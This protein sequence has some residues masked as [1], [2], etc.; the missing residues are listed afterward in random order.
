MCRIVAIMVV[1][2][3]VACGESGPLLQRDPTADNAD[4]VRPPVDE[5]TDE[6]DSDDAVEPTVETDTSGPATPSDAG[7]VDP[8]ADVVVEP[9]EPDSANPDTAGVEDTAP[10]DT[11]VDAPTADSNDGDTSDASDVP[12]KP[13]SRD[14]DTPPDVSDPPDTSYDLPEFVRIEPGTFIMGSPVT[15]PG[16]PFRSDETQHSVTLTRA[17]LLQTTEVTQ[18]QWKALSGGV[19]PS[20][21]LPGR[22]AGCGDGCPVETLNWFAAVAFTNAMSGREGLQECYVLEGC[23]DEADG[24]KDGLHEGCSDARFVGLDC[25]GYRLPTEAEWEYAARAGTTTATWAGELTG[26]ECE[27][28]TLPPIA[29]IC[30]A[31]PQLV[32]TRPANPWGLHD[33]LGNVSEFTSTVYGEYSGPVTDPTGPDTGP[34][35]VVR[36]GDFMRVPNAAAATRVA[37]RRS[38]SRVWR[39]YSNGFRLART[40]P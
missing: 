14:T 4:A 34:Y 19:N 24:W 22:S 1:V 6:T 21:F 26:L 28:L 15:E 5:D 29:W 38:P 23:T 39:F 12:E 18:G 33:M 13:E 9:E 31:Y 25:T 2:G 10:I 32:A 40:V 3:C 30:Q 7:V 36:G 16:R 17:F 8:V 27:D 35:I 20:Y 11:T 37:Y